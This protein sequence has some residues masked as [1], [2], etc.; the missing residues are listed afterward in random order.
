[1]RIIMRTMLVVAACLVPFAIASAVLGQGASSK[2]A[3]YIT[4]E[5]IDNVR[6]IFHLV[7]EKG[8]T[9]QGA[10]EMLRNNLSKYYKSLEQND[11]LLSRCDRVVIYV[12]TQ[13]KDTC[14]VSRKDE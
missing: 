11:F 9:L 2:P 14:T 4:K 12:M 1:M 13:I 5:D 10:K 7:K 6:T 8:F 3:T